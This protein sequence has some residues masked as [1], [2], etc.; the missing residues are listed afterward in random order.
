MKAMMD[1]FKQTITGDA[2]QEMESL[3]ERLTSVSESLVGI[4]ET[5]TDITLQV[6]ETIEALKETV[7]TNI[8]QSKNEAFELTVD[9]SE[10]IKEL[11]YRISQLEKGGSDE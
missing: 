3:I 8:E 9:K 6:A 7:V 10:M 1:D 11:E 2:K 4:P 5:M